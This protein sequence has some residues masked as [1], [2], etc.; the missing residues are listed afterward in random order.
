[1]LLGLRSVFLTCGNP[2]GLLG[3]VT[4]GVLIDPLRACDAPMDAAPVAMLKRA[5]FRLG[6]GFGFMPQLDVRD[7]GARLSLDWRL[8]ACGGSS[9]EDSSALLGLRLRR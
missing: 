3:E 8:S 6:V 9:D 4:E 1:M 7:G 2:K 5:V